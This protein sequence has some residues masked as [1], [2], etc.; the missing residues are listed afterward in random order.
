MSILLLSGGV[1]CVAPGFERA[2]AGEGS[3]PLVEVTELALLPGKLRGLPRGG[4]DWASLPA[5]GGR[6]PNLARL[7]RDGVSGYLRNIEPT[8]SPVIWTSVAT[9]EGPGEHGIEDFLMPA[10]GAKGKIHVSSTLRRTPALWN[11]VTDY[12]QSSVGVVSWWA[13]WPAE[14]V[15]GFIVTDHANEGA[16]R[17]KEDRGYLPKA[18]AIRVVYG[19]YDT[20]P[21]ELARRLERQPVAAS[22]LRREDLQRLLPGLD[23][24]LWRR[25][26]D[27]PAV[28]RLDSESLLKFYLLKD[29]VT[30]RTGLPLFEEVSPDLWMLYFNG[31]DSLQHRF[32]HYAD[33]DLYPRADRAL[34]PL[35][36][37]VVENYYALVDD[38]I[39][40]IAAAAGPRANLIVLSD[41]GV[42]G[43]DFMQSGLTSGGH[44]WR[45]RGI[46]IASGPAFE[47]GRYTET[48]SI[49]DI[50]PTALALLDYPVAVEL[51]GK[52]LLQLL[53]P[54]WR[55]RHAIRNIDRYEFLSPRSGA[56]AVD[57]EFGAEITERLRALGY[58]D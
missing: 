28:D 2:G 31:Q 16:V 7:I 24:A 36:G 57:G 39:G 12:G 13:S 29:L 14:A 53:R 21:R 52:P 6:L 58:L 54:E 32:W 17:V 45:S 10:P 9:G 20:Y 43:V 46:L 42:H 26:S 37:S 23:E 33:P 25:F 38:F 41:H 34:L 8:L 40:Q 30:L 22:G 11:I 18:A 3:N 44:S 27:I 1:D 4:F 56:A 51:E 48:A 35:Y 47:R 50:A 5:D 15:R 55:Q 49:F 19:E